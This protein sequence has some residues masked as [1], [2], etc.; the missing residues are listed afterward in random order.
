MELLKGKLIADSVKKRIK[1]KIEEKVSSGL[2][3]PHLAAILVGED[4]AS[5][6]YVGN[7][8]K[9]C[10]QVGIKSTVLRFPDTITE[11]SLI[12]EIKKLNGNPEIDGFIV[13]MPLPPHIDE[14]KIIDAIDP[15]KD[16]DGFNPVNLGNMVIGRPTFLPATPFG[17]MTLL[18]EYN[19]ETSGKNCV[20]IGRSNIVGKPLS[21]MLSAKSYPGDCT[22]T[23]CHSHTGNVGLY[24]KNA[25]IVVAALG[26]PHFLKADMVKD[27]AVVIDVGI[28]RIPG[29]GGSYK[30]AGDV[31]FENV[32]PKCSFISP[33]PGGVGPMTI[34]SLLEN[35]YKA[36]YGENI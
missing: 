22:V 1:E 11:D 7:K 19:I 29:E 4:G 12:E 6:T 17:I 30:L 9:A 21:I 28:T 35:T 5:L 32:A 24:T 16:V 23:L 15:C 25:D 10:S 33:V 2:R 31:D 34:V 27:G 20:I 14:Q 18:E 36:A 8:E 3:A 26:V 13:Q